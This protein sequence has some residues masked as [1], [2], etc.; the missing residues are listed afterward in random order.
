MLIHAEAVIVCFY[1]WLNPVKIAPRKQ[2]I[3]NRALQTWNLS[4]LHPNCQVWKLLR[5]D[6]I[7]LRCHLNRA[8]VPLGTTAGRQSPKV[9]LTW[10]LRADRNWKKVTTKCI[11]QSF[12]WNKISVN[13]TGHV[14]QRG[15]SSWH[16][17]VL[18]VWSLVNLNNRAW[19]H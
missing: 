19:S 6:S 16:R 7:F 10:G 13:Q 15:H 4:F 2:W 9:T 12:I 1:R 11:S 14:A 17:W 8:T 5:S 18:S 3:P